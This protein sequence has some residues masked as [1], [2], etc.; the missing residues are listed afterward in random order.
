MQ[1]TVEAIA[2]KLTDNYN[3]EM[4]TYQVSENCMDALDKM[5]M[6]KMSKKAVVG[7]ATNQ[8]L[9]LPVDVFDVKS[10]L[11][12][13]DARETLTNSVTLT[14]QDFITHPP[15]TVFVPVPNSD[16]EVQEITLSDQILNYIPSMAGPYIDYTWEAPFLSFNEERPAVVAIYNRI[17]VDP[18]TGL[19]QIPQQAF[20]GCLNYCLYVWYQPL[21]LSGKVPPYVWAELKE[22][23]Q[24]GMAQSKNSYGMSRLS[25]NQ[26]SKVHNIMSSFDRHRY[27]LDS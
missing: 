20:F 11:R 4:D 14:I 21:F 23:K 26:M 22:W 3:V 25:R 18:E 13:P 10:V 6:L 16:S 19:C 2:S 5:G 8:K 9:R 7:R 27:G 24:K 17:P 15:Q 12:L 1:T